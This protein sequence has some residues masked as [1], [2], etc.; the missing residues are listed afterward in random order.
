MK[1]MIEGPSLIPVSGKLPFLVLQ[2]Q[3]SEAVR[4]EILRSLLRTPTQGVRVQL[5]LGWN[6]CLS[7]NFDFG[8][9]GCQACEV[10]K[11]SILLVML[12][13]EGWCGQFYTPVCTSHALKVYLH[14]TFTVPSI[15][16]VEHLHHELFCRNSQRVKAVDCFRRRAP[17]C[18]FDR[19]FDRILNGKLPSNFI[20]LEE[21]LRRSFPPLQLH[22]RIL[23]SPTF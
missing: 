14:S 13:G 21:G 7:I 16:L 1:M 5:T 15:N 22:K 8:N 23:D 3:C 2:N 17:S 4:H 11:G 19:M 9:I 12:V 6:T 10:E 20:Q 18:I